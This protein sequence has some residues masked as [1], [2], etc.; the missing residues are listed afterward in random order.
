M[1]VLRDAPYLVGL[2]VAR[3]PDS[4]QITVRKPGELQQTLAVE[5]TAPRAATG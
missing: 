2:G 4:I 3:S 1:N 5:T